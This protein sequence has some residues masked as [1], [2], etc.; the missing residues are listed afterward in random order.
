MTARDV[1]SR[2]RYHDWVDEQIEEYKSTLTRDELLEVAEHAVSRLFDSPDGQYPLT[3]ILLCDAVDVLLLERL[4]LPDY[5][6]WRKSC[7][8]DTTKRPLNRTRADLRAAS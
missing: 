3:E 6:R 4:K 8:N 7:R 1:A 5:R 2:Q